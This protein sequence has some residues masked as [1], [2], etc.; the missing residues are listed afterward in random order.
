MALPRNVSAVFL[1]VAC[2]AWTARAAEPATLTPRS[3]RREPVRLVAFSGGELRYFNAERNLAG[4][5]VAEAVRLEFERDDTSPPASASLR[6]IDGQ[7]L[8]GSLAG[9]AEGGKLRWQSAHLGVLEVEL[10]SVSSFHASSKATPG[11]LPAPGESDTVTLS[12]GDTINGFIDALSP[13]GLKVERDGQKVELAWD[14]VDAVVLANPVREPP[15]VWLNLVG[16]GRVRVEGLEVSGE[17]ARGKVMGQAAEIPLAS[18]R[19]IDFFERHRLVGLSDLPH[20]VAAGGKVFGVDY[21]PVLREGRV[22]LHAPLTL[23]FDLP[24]G[25]RRFAA[26]AS[27][28]P[29]GLDWADLVLTVSGDGGELFKEHLQGGK[30][31]SSLLVEI[32]GLSLTLQLDEGAKGPIRDRLTLRDA[33][34][35]IETP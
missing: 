33:H 5:G 29:K 22:D 16:G 18:I 13:Q 7:S 4:M 27:L 2:V 19:S 31:E 10:D 15:G 23:R 26:T 21:P 30:P 24:S 9:V 35:L 11:A 25:A 1:C 8:P 20:K 3:L 34:L 17:A 6:L 14:A 12:N 28:D 32:Q